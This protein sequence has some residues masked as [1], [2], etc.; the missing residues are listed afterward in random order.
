MSNKKAL[1]PEQV[2]IIKRS[3]CIP[4]QYEVV[5]DCPHSLLIRNIKT[6]QPRLI[7]KDQIPRR[8]R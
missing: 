3:G 8:L 1:T 7:D 4:S 6:K 2:S 5:V